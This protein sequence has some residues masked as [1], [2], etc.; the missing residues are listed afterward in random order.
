MIH[1]FF[2]GGHG[3]IGFRWGSLLAERNTFIL[4]GLGFPLTPE[5]HRF[6]Q[7]C[8][9][10]YRQFFPEILDEIRGIAE[11][12]RCAEEALHAFLFSMYALPPVCHCSCFAVANQ[13]GVL[14]GR[15]SDFL[16]ALEACN[17]HVVYRLPT[18]S[19]I[20][21]TTAFVQMEDGVNAYG[22]AVGLTSVH[23][24]AVRPGMNAGLL[25][26]YFLEKCRTTQEVVR[27]IRRLPIAS[28]QTFTV[29][30]ASGEIAVIEC[31][32]DALD[33]LYPD[34]ESPYVCATNRF[35]SP[36][37]ERF[38]VPNLDDW[39][40]EPRYQSLSRALARQAPNMRAADACALLSGR[41]G[42]LCP[43]DRASGRDTVWSI[44][45]DLRAQRL[46]QADGNPC[47][48]AFVCN[49]HFPLPP[50]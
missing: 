4:Q 39:Q 13:S 44:V 43:Y 26:R 10:F 19:F 9:P 12:Q 49:E 8:L 18:G 11:G 40:A 2:E 29:A 6:A 23:P 34:A 20:G 27:Q 45:C 17:R 31:N 25:L 28:A 41:G 7:A 47:R 37:M 30:D 3:D 33:M 1:E 14:F 24:H 5:R 46:Y 16:T 32:C 48:H 21:N 15:N 38:N 36:R 35:H 42:F 50:M 22:L